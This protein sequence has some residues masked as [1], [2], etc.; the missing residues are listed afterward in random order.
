MKVLIITS[1]F[2]GDEY[3]KGFME[4]ITSQSYFTDCE[5]FMLDAN[6]PHKEYTVIKEYM[7][8][9]SNITYER[10]E[11]DNGL[12]DCW[13]YMIKNSNSEYITNANL[14][15]RQFPD[16]IEKHVEFLDYN[17]DI[18]VVYSYNIISNTVIDYKE[19]L[20]NKKEYSIFPCYQF[21]PKSLLSTNSPHNHPMWR[22]SLHEKNGYFSTDYK[23][24]SDWEFWLRCAANGSKMHLIPHVLGIYYHN[25]NG[26][27]TAS[28]NM[29]RNYA[30]VSE[31]YSKYSKI[32]R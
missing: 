6:S 25:P 23:S 3:I 16:S 5:L 21:S 10:L 32:I 29:Q 13:N 4:D 17:Q 8:K 31:I 22:R 2:K 26:I 11:K 1:V 9:Y 24:A 27:S 12:Y 7:K 14:D 28:D 30:E 20:K 19:V 15:D 18:D